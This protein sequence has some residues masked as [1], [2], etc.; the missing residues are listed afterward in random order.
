MSAIEFRVLSQHTVSDGYDV[1]VLANGDCQTVHFATKP[2]D[3]Q[4]AIAAW[5]AS[6]PERV[7]YAIEGE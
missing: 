2:T 3:V 1:R 4:A 7:E 6:L 5:V